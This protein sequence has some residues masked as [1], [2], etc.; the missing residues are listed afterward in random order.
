M[1]SAMM[2]PGMMNAGMMGSG[3]SGG[4]G[5]GTPL[6]RYDFILHFTWQPVVP[7]TPKPAAEGDGTAGN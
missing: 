7:G 3:G 5:E 6:R 1:S 2:Q 4:A